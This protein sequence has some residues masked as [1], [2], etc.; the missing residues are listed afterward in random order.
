MLQ[1]TWLRGLREHAAVFGPA[2]DALV[3]MPAAIF[4]HHFLLDPAPDTFFL[5]AFV[6][7]QLVG[8]LRFSRAPG[9][10]FHHTGHISALYVIPEA[11]GHGVGAGLLREAI[12]CAITVPGIECVTL[13]VVAAPRPGKDWYRACGFLPAQRGPMEQMRHQH[14]FAVYWFTIG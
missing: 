10:R 2:Y 4:V 11:R 12:T 3:A 1:H 5:G 14:P 7:D 8:M 13:T 9:I 6:H